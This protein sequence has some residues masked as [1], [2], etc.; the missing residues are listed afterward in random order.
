MTTLLAALT[1][2]VCA[3]LLVRLAI[4]ERWRWRFDYEVRRAWQA[5]RH[6]A[7]GVV[8][9]RSARRQAAREAEQ[10][11]RRARRS[12]GEWDGN[13]YKPDSDSFRK[14]RKPH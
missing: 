5:C 7:H 10:A 13:V 6:L 12:K 1:L 9:W 4:G 3:V 8:H 11:I 2:A 14:P